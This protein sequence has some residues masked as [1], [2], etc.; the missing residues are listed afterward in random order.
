VRTDDPIYSFVAQ[1]SAD[2]QTWVI[3]ELEVAVGDSD[4]G[5]DF[6]LLSITYQGDAPTMFIRVASETAN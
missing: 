4:L 5:S 2:L 3:T 6:E 1:R